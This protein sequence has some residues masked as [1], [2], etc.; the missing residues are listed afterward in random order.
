MAC[1]KE[2]AADEIGKIRLSADIKKASAE[3][4]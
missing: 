4:G 2:N 3:C 1:Y